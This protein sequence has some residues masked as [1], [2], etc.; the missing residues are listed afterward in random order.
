[1]KFELVE[2]VDWDGGEEQEESA[3]ETREEEENS[4]EENVEAVGEEAEPSP[5]DRLR[6]A[7]AELKADVRASAAQL[8]PV[9]ARL[10]ECVASYDSGAAVS[11]H[12][13]GVRP[14]SSFRAERFGAPGR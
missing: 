4:S 10:Q 3:D 11:G 9:L 1:M 7:T 6:A 14:P 13:S 8:G 12:G 2:P 5:M